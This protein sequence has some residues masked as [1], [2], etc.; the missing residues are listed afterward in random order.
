MGAARTARDSPARRVSGPVELARL[1]A[2][3]ERAVRVPRAYL[4]V[5]RVDADRRQRKLRTFDE[6]REG[7]IVVDLDWLRR[8][9]PGAVVRFQLRESGQVLGTAQWHVPER[10]EGE[11]LPE[12]NSQPAAPVPVAATAPA[13]VQRLR[14]ELAAVRGEARHLAEEVRRLRTELSQE[15]AARHRAE[16]SR[17]AAREAEGRSRKALDKLREKH[18]QAALQRKE[19]ELAFR[20]LLERVPEDVA[21]VYEL[22]RGARPPG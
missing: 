15:Q 8:E 20:L 16:A 5:S 21:E 13:E 6:R 12:P 7:R 17:D 19:S 2:L 22:V 14:E 1:A 9:C 3:V 10:D 11:E 4:A 18:H